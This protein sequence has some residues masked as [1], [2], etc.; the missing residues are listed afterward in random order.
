M[1]EALQQHSAW[2]P[3]SRVASLSWTQCAEC[4]SE[5]CQKVRHSQQAQ[6]SSS[7]EW[8]ESGPP[9]PSGCAEHSLDPQPSTCGTT[10]AATQ[11]TLRR[12]KRSDSG[13]QQNISRAYAQKL[14]AQACRKLRPHSHKVS[15]EVPLGEVLQLVQAL[16]KLYRVHPVR[17]SSTSASGHPAAQHPCTTLAG[18]SN[19]AGNCVR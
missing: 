17:S 4:S 5:P 6:P 3:W 7:A 15:A 9:L 19:G 14:A 8:A 16:V 1:V 12:R 18:N 2:T 10:R 11:G 13:S